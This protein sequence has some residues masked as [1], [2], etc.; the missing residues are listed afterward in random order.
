[1]MAVMSGKI[2]SSGILGRKEEY[3]QET[4]V[5]TPAQIK[6]I[7]QAILDSGKQYAMKK[8]KPFPLMYSY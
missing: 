7:C 8:R 3:S 1:M 5:L 4:E 2:E 6:S